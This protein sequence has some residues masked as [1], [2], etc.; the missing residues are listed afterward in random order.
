MLE[1]HALHRHRPAITDTS[2][3]PTAG[4]SVRKNR[5]RHHTLSR[6]THT[7]SPDRGSIEGN[8]EHPSG[9]NHDVSR[10]PSHSCAARVA[11]QAHE[12]RSDAP[13]ALS[14]SSCLICGATAG[15]VARSQL[16]RA[17]SSATFHPVPLE[18]ATSLLLRDA[19]DGGPASSASVRQVVA[20]WAEVP[21]AATDVLTDVAGRNGGRV[22]VREETL[23]DG[24]ARW[25]LT[26]L[27]AD[28]GDPS[29]EW[30]TVV[31]ALFEVTATSL[32]I[33]LLRESHD[34]RYRVSVGEGLSGDLAPRAPGVP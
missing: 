21:E 5:A 4:S 19:A 14:G 27:I 29:V 34:P 15:S 1:A 25:R 9:R 2:T 30:T 17:P 18:L 28:A 10:P 12:Q 31:T 11:L 3:Q 22:T 20:D 13:S 8:H 23:A 33:Q 24:G 6:I 32:S 16:R 7:E 26:H